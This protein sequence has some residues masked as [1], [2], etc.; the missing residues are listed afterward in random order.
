MSR[1]TSTEQQQK[2]EIGSSSS[3][4]SSVT[5][6]A[7]AAASSTLSVR[8]SYILVGVNSLSGECIWA[9]LSLFSYYP[10]QAFFSV[11]C[12]FPVVSFPTLEVS[13][14]CK[15]LEAFR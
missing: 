5:K 3:A 15:R 2:Q 14:K 11:S 1:T 8:T 4:S 10:G 6:A 9:I 13:V 7:A 12:Q